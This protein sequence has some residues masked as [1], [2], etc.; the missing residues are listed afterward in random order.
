MNALQI[1]YHRRL[2]DQW[3]IL[4]QLMGELHTDSIDGGPRGQL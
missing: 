1:V 3:E 2:F 4:Q